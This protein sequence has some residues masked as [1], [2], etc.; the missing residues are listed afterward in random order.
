MDASA[1]ATTSEHGEQRG[2]RAA[3]SALH[4]SGGGGRGVGFDFYER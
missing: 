2:N 3:L 4:R 1:G